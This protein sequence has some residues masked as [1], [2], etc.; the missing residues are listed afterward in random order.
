MGK[1]MA[2]ENK[3]HHIFNSQESIEMTW[4]FLENFQL[5]NLTIKDSSR[6]TY[7]K[8]MDSW[9]SLMDKNTWVFS[10]TVSSMVKE[11][12]YLKTKR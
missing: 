10:K 7:L 12:I 8:A 6:I 1:C 11:F 9:D 2:G 4:N 5:H 3:S